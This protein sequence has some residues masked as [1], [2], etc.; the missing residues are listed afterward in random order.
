MIDTMAA[1]DDWRESGSTFSY[2]DHSIFYQD[3]TPGDHSRPVL[4]CLHGFPTA[5]WDWRRVWPLLG[6]GYRLLA[7]DFIG[8]G[9]SAKPRHYDYSFFD[10]M[11]LVEAL[12]A[13][14]EIE[15]VHVLAH[16]YG[17]TVLQE[18]LARRQEGRLPHDG[19]LTMQSAC[20]LNG[21]I[22]P[23]AI[24]PRPVQTLL[25][26]SA[27][28]LATRLINERLFAR[29]LSSVF[30][31]ASRPT[32]DE[33]KAYWR[34]ASRNNGLRITTRLIRYMDER[35][36]HR[37]RW[38]GALQ[39]TDLPLRLVWGPL[40]PVSGRPVAERYRELV[41]D[42]DV[43]FLEGIGHYPQLEDPA[44]VVRELLA[45]QATI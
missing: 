7:P 28:A 33:L 23:E 21:G 18:W 37:A 30:G 34:L 20:L 32:A 10:Q 41:P 25:R 42:A 1:L 44:G 14:L 15:S 4:L 8:F 13:H 45:F 11:D 38:A 17:D 9:F 39:E 40:D 26:S 22:F 16:D 43:V 24:R 2:R 29:S 35:E 19:T 31:P 27:G 6:A 3:S 5:S 36:A 12:L